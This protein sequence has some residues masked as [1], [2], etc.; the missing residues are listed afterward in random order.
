MSTSFWPILITRHYSFNEQVITVN[1]TRHSGQL[2]NEHVIPV[3]F[4]E[5]VISSVGTSS[6]PPFF[7][8]SHCLGLRDCV[9]AAVNS[10]DGDVSWWS[11]CGDCRVC[12]IGM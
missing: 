3:S 10:G 4:N 11:L 1:F 5:H 6:R 2:Y 12:H 9:K 7:R 8:S